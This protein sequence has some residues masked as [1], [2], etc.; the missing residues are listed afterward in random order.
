MGADDEVYPAVRDSLLHRAA[1]AGHA[2]TRGDERDRHAGAEQ[3]FQGGEVLLGQEFG[4]RHQRRLQAAPGGDQTGEGRQ[5]RLAAAH[6]ALYQTQHGLP[7]GEIVGYLSEHPFLRA[8]QAKRQKPGRRH[9]RVAV[10]AVAVGF[11]GSTAL[12][13]GHGE[14]QLLEQELTVGEAGMGRAPPGVQFLDRGFPR[15]RVNFRQGFR[16]SG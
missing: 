5:D 2:L 12:A 9:P 3:S 11:P 15:R 1:V 8:G 14:L 4:R 13:T 6:V 16:Q 10:G 7:P